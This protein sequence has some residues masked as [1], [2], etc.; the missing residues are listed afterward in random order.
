MHRVIIP[1]DYQ[2]RDLIPKGAALLELV[3]GRA[4]CYFEHNA[5]FADRCQ[6]AARGQG[7][8]VKL[9]F[10]TTYVGTYD[11]TAGELRPDARYG[12]S[13]LEKWYGRRVYRNDLEAK[14]NRNDRR[15]QA[16]RLMMQGRTAEAYRLDKRLG[17]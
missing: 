12:A 9:D 17:L 1:K 8:I 10:E 4:I 5:S 2:P 14:D 15:A 13:L 6:A 11:D 3:Q 7:R 16:R